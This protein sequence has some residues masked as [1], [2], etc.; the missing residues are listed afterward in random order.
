MYTFIH[1]YN[2]CL[3][4]QI[5]LSPFFFS[6]CLPTQGRKQKPQKIS[7]HSQGHRVTKS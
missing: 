4:S 5:K 3:E 6:L 2:T 7:E 1:N